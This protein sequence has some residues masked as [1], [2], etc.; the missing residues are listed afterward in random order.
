MCLEML[1]GGFEIVKT[2]QV[3]S[4]VQVMKVKW[5]KHNG[6]IYR[7]HLVVCGAVECEIPLF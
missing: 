5:A 7:Q 6:F 2:M 4:S 3:H 1:K